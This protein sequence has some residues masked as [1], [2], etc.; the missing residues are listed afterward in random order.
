MNAILN[1]PLFAGMEPSTVAIIVAFVLLWFWMRALR[2]LVFYAGLGVI[3]MALWPEISG[4]VNNVRNDPQMSSLIGNVRD[5]ASK[6]PS[7]D[8]IKSQVQKQLD[9]SQKIGK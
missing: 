9:N 4:Y 2:R 7:T 5:M 3:A 8:E 1:S 6:L